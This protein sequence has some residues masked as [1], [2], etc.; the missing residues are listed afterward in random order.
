MIQAAL[1][2]GVAQLMEMGY[3]RN[4]H[5]TLCCPVLQD[6]AG[7]AG[8]I[9]LDSCRN[10]ATTGVNTKH[11]AAASLCRRDDAGSAGGWCCTADGEQ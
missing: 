4:K 9:L 5:L 10:R 6:D 7:S 8:A 3:R 2:A 1:E 11:F